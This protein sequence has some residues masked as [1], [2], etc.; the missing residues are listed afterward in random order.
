MDRQED[1]HRLDLRLALAD[2]VAD[3][4]ACVRFFSR[5]PVPKLC[6]ADDPARLPDFSQISR[7]IPLAGIVVAMPAGLLVLL[8]GLSQLPTLASGFLVVGMLAMVTGALHED[9]LADVAD[10][11]FGGHTPERR[12]EIMKDSRIG[13]FGSIALIVSL[14]LKAVLIA[15]LL[16]RYTPLEAMVILLGA[17]SL[18]RTLIVWQWST[19]PAARPDGLAHRFGVPISKTF[20]QACIFG[21]ACLLPTLPVL[22]LPS[23]ALGLI[24]APLAAH[25]VGMLAKAR[26]GGFSGD[27]LGAVQ[28]VGTLV[29]L[30]GCL[31]VA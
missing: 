16:D 8:L 5:L 13:A 2:L 18:G 29:F 30:A 24:L 21:A 22:P 10:G 28:Q 6:S 26:I 17:E 11:F 31:A 25:G 27:V 3:T 9:G 1:R 14:G 4:A 20:K 7:A 12:L 23:L 15:A 19:L